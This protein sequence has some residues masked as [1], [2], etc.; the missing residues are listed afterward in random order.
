MGLHQVY[1]YIHDGSY[2]KKKQY[3]KNYGWKFPIYDENINLHI[4]GAQLNKLHVE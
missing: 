2:R 4:Q 1:Q 3:L